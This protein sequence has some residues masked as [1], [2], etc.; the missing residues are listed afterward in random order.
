MFR[1]L[2]IRNFRGL[3]NLTVDGIGRI[4]LISGR[5]N[6]GKTSLLESIFLLSGW[7]NP[8]LVLNINAFRG[9]ESLSGPPRA[10]RDTFWKP[11]FSD[12]AIDR[13]I[14]ISGQFRGIGQLNLKI[15]LSQQSTTEIRFEDSERILTAPTMDQDTL[16]FEFT[17]RSRHRSKGSITPAGQG[18]Q[19]KQPNVSVKYPATFLSSRSADRRED[20][21]RLGQLRTSKQGHIVVE[22]L[23]KIE[24]RLQSIEVS[25]AGGNPMIWGDI[26]M[27]ELIP[28]PMMGEGLTRIASLVLAIATAAGGVVLVDEI[29]N[30]LHHSVLSKVWQTVEEAAIR[31]KTQIFATTH[32]FECVQA[33]S[34]S[35]RDDTFSYHRLES[36]GG[37]VRCNSYNFAEIRSA[38]EHELEVR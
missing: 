38:I 20:A 9:L 13:K 35:L 11:L 19:V 22:A 14:E 23:Q 29:E 37:Q 24:P 16:E 1:I 8:S 18:L 4:N 15:S 17:E 6:S 2:R 36:V 10:L 7:G 34:S 3:P 21:S 26:G 33:A 28:L 12:L 5:N 31:S 32:S 25:T 30:G 27:A